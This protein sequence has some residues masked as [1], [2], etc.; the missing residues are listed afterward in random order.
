MSLQH[1]VTHALGAGP[2]IT[3]ADIEAQIKSCIFVNAFEA[4]V[5]KQGANKNAGM[6]GES[7]VAFVPWELQVLTICLMVLKNGFTVVGKS[8]CVSPENYD[9]P[10]GEKIA[11]EDAIDQIWPL[12][13]YA[14]RDKIAEDAEVKRRMGGLGEWQDRASML[15][16]SSELERAHKEFGYIPKPLDLTADMEV[17]GAKASDRAVMLQA[18]TTMIERGFYVGQ[19]G[20]DSICRQTGEPFVTYAFQA[21]NSEGV[22]EEVLVAKIVHA[23]LKAGLGKKAIYWRRPIT[24]EESEEG[25]SIRARVAFGP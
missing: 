18:A 23:I 15:Y 10:L 8:A 13:G 6:P 1:A 19:D 21:R 22:G 14:L 25:K 2:K 16:A 9:R 3:P 12:M 17:H 7:A 5:W 24:L 20:M 11:R 4:A